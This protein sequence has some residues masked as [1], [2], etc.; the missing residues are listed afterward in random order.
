[1]RIAQLGDFDTYVCRGLERPRELLPVR[2][3]TGLNLVRGFKEVGG[4]E[5][6]IVVTTK[7]VQRTTVEEGP[8]GIVHRLPQPWFSG[9]ACFHYWRRA[10]ILREL[11]K[12]KPDLVHGQGTEAEYAFTAVTSPYPHVITF[13]GIM[14]RVHEVVP[15]PFLSSQHVARWLEKLVVQRAQDVICIS[16]AVATF[17]HERNPRVR[18]HLIPNA[19]APCFFT[20]VPS[21][22]SPTAPPS[23]QFVGSLYRLKGL[24]DLVEALP[25]VSRRLG[26]PVRLRVVGPAPASATGAD[27]VRQ[28]R[29][30]AEAL[31]VAQQI[32]WLGAQTETEVA[33]ALAQ[34]D[35]LVLPSYEENA[36]MC[37]AEA[38][39]AG[40]P[41]VAT[42]VGGIPQWVRDGEDGLLVEPGDTAALADALT[43]TLTDDAL[44]RRMG[45]AGRAKAMKNY[46]P[47][48]VAEKTLAVYAQVLATGCGTAGSGAS[49]GG[50][51]H[52][53][54]DTGLSAGDATASDGVAAD[55]QEQVAGREKRQ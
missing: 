29:L 27:Y 35:V 55:D 54:A 46:T 12:I 30:R 36:P 18:C 3:P 34:S 21:L 25:L 22:P 24:H 37:V 47:R 14:H 48:I 45:R 20:A 7:E 15:P 23:L 16:N 32:E 43:K 31:H 13:H 8:F 9:S 50:N 41:V 19:V 2:Q 53:A 52:A 17:V 11:A 5:V 51:T 42:R 6:H 49:G 40:V 44:R 26:Q 39:A 1:M 38:M 28:L 10:L 33:D 4:H